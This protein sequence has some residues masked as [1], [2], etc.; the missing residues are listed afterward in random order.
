MHWRFHLRI[1]QLYPCECRKHR[2]IIQELTPSFKSSP[3]ASTTASFSAVFP[4]QG[5]QPRTTTGISTSPLQGVMFM[6]LLKQKVG[7]DLSSAA[8]DG[9]ATNLNSHHCH[10]WVSPKTSFCLPSHQLCKPRSTIDAITAPPIIAS[11]LQH[12]K[13]LVIYLPSIIK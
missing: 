13:D 4:N 1:W 2:R 7:V 10:R 12:L 5:S 11:P 9:D 8:A 6:V 3:A